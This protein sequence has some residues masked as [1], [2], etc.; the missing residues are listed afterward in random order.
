MNPLRGRSIRT[1]AWL[2]DAAYER[3]VR[4]RLARRG[5]FPTERLDA[6]KAD[7]VRAEAQAS[8]LAEIRSELTEHEAAIARRGRNANLPTSARGRK[9]T[10]DYRDATGFEALIALWALQEGEWGWARF[11]QVVAKRLEASIDVALAKRSNK[12]QR[13]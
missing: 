11:E 13:G 6:A 5:D 3:E 12:P 4:W 1:L 10:R 2:G 8:M 7:I 9:N